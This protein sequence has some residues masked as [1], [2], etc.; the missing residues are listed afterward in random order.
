M[1]FYIY[2][3]VEKEVGPIEAIKKSWNLTKGSFWN[4][5]LF[6]LLSGGIQILGIVALLIGLVFTTPT[7]WIARAV[8]YEKLK[9][10]K[11]QKNLE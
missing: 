8:V 9:A 2:F 4:L 1:H 11:S 6:G 10:N 5:F 7:V 3:I